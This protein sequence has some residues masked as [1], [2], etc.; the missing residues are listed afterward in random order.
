MPGFIGLGEDN[1]TTRRETSKFGDLVR[2]I[3][4][5]LRKFVLE[6]KWR[7]PINDTEPLLNF[8]D[9]LYNKMRTAVSISENG[10]PRKL[11]WCVLAGRTPDSCH[12]ILRLQLSIMTLMNFLLSRKISWWRHQTETFS[13]TGPLCGEFTGPGEFPTQRPVTRS[14][15]VFL[16]LR[17]NKRLSKQWW[18]WWFETP[19]WS[20][21]R[22]C[23][24]KGNLE[25]MMTYWHGN[26]FRI[27]GPFRGDPSVIGG[28]PSQRDIRSFGVLFSWIVEQQWVCRCWNKLQQTSTYWMCRQM[29][30]PQYRLLALFELCEF[31]S[32]S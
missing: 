9:K 7:F 16:D 11:L 26:A 10:I 32:Y 4:E 5:I 15:D 1:C 25:P 31:L 20:L 22:Q 13:V 27:A 23:N 2:R 24:V 19:S 14:F 12:L 8:Y 30:T 3:L 6:I 21:W 29:C 17:L 18:G 28:F